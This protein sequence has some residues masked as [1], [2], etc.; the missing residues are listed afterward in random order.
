MIQS[1]PPTAKPSE[2][3]ILLAYANGYYSAE[4]IRELLNHKHKQRIYKT[5]KKYSHLLPT[6]RLSD[7]RHLR[8]SRR[9]RTRLAFGRT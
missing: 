3:P 7:Q 1:F 2:T 5:L 8:D 9:P 6:L 4:S